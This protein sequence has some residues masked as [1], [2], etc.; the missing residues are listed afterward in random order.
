MLS[1]FISRN[2]PDQTAVNM[3]NFLSEVNI[4]RKDTLIWNIVPWYIG[5]DEKIHGKKTRRPKSN[6]I[7]DGLEH[8]MKLLKLFRLPGLKAI[9]LLGEKAQKVKLQLKQKLPKLNLFSCP[10]PSPQSVGTK[11]KSKK[12]WKLVK[13]KLQHVSNFLLENK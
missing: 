6:E 13:E 5:D 4:C 7:K 10:H 9:V 3:C 2:N 11:E 8:L 12:N 1:G